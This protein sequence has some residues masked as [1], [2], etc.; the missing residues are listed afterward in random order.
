M[1]KELKYAIISFIF[2][3]ETQFQLMNNTS[4]EFK[5]YIYDS[6]G[7]YL[8]GGEEVYN[9]IKNAVKLLAK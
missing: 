7:N 4:E 3:N 5:A 8:I 6:K 1:N 2:E 9:F